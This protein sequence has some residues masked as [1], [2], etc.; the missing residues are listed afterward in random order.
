MSTDR[1]VLENLE[2]ATVT[3]GEGAFASSSAV[4]GKLEAIRAEAGLPALAAAVWR[5][6]TLIGSWASGVRKLGDPT[7][8]TTADEWHLGSDTKAMTATLIG[9]LVDRGQLAFSDRLDTVLAGE[10]I[11]PG[12]RATTIEQ[13]LQH[14]GGAPATMPADIRQRMWSDGDAPDARIRAVRSLLSRPPAQAPATYA[15]A[16]AG[17]LILG[18]VLERIAKMP[19][20][21]MIRT[22]L[23]AKLGMTSAGFGPPGNGDA[24]DQPWGH[25]NAG[26]PLVPIAPA[27]PRAD[28]P[29]AYGPAGRVHV[30]LADWG[31]FLTMHVRGAR[32][33]PT[34]LSPATMARLHQP[35]PGGDYAAGWGVVTRDWAGGVALTHTGSN[36][37]WLATTW[38]EPARDVAFATATNCDADSAGT[39]LDDAAGVLIEA[40]AGR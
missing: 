20:E 4:A 18:T 35:P 23:F 5:G 30:G 8:V 36:T 13:L 17:Y 12:Y 15:Y 21:N 1:R 40:F 28:N 37:L 39:A 10:T 27:D 2:T 24:V 29:P 11:D 16:N 31:K 32:G 6:G 25:T 14:R 7:P 33:E 3:G 34:L 9:L 22:E 38:L 19:W 26:N